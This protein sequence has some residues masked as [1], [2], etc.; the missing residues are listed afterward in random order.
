MTKM[1]HSV[2]TGKGKS[3]LSRKTG[4]SPSGN[5]TSHVMCYCLMRCHTRV[6]LILNVILVP[7]MLFSLIIQMYITNYKVCMHDV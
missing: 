1:G 6:N 4:G 2:K 5:A 7:H 3:T